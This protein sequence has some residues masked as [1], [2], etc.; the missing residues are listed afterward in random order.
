LKN[1][2]NLFTTLMDR[3]V[4]VFLFSYFIFHWLKHMLKM[5]F[6]NGTSGAALG[7]QLTLLLMCFCRY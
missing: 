1:E 5:H 4:W 3:I 2:D 7:K 6:Y